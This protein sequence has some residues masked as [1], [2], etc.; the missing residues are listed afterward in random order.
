MRRAPGPAL[1]VPPRI[2]ER[3][4]ERCWDAAAAAHTAPGGRTALR[5]GS[6]RTGTRNGK[7]LRH[8][9]DDASSLL[10]AMVGR[11]QEA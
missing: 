1:Q 4:A 9:L 8:L 3:Q 5:K 10:D 6:R 2:T 11:A 7:R